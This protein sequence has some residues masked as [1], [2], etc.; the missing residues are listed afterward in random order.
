VFRF[1][2]LAC[3]AGLRGTAIDGF[4]ASW[5]GS[6]VLLR[7]IGALNWT[8]VHRAIREIAIVLASDIAGTAS[9]ISDLPQHRRCTALNRSMFGPLAY[10]MHWRARRR[11]DMFALV[12]L[13][14]LR[15]KSLR[16]RYAA[17]MIR[18]MDLNPP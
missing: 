15:L 3:V 17:F 18:R 9:S 8:L 4:C 7:K 10:R 14:N 16:R 12:D 6:S 5:L 11:Q 13:S 1:A 2:L